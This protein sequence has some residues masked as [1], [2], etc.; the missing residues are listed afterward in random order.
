MFCTY[1]H[2]LYGTYNACLI[3]RSVILLKSVSKLLDKQQSFVPRYSK[4]Q[5]LHVCMGTCI[6]CVVVLY[7]YTIASSSGPTGV[8]LVLV[9][10]T[11]LIL[12]S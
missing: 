10:I 7:A 12:L 8:H 11:L 3:S 4:F 2:E 5:L 1:N 9:S 6:V